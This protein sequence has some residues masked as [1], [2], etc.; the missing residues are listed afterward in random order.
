MKVHYIN[1]LLFELLL[2]ILVNTHRNPC[3]TTCHTQTNRSLCECELYAPSNYDND[4]QM[5]FV[6]ENFNRQT[7]QRFHEYDERMKTTR[8]KCREQCHKEI[9][10]IILKDKMEKQMAQQLTTLETKI[11]TDDIPTCVCE[12]S[13]ADKMEKDCL[14]CTYGLGTLAPTVGLIGSVAVGAWK[15]GALEAAIE[16]AIAKSAAEISAAANAAGIQAGKIAVIEELKTLTIYNVDAKLL[17]SI[18]GS[19]NNTALTMISNIISQRNSELCSLN[20]D[21]SFNG[22]CTQLKISLRIVESNGRTPLLPHANAIR[23]KAQEIVTKVEG[24]AADASA[25]KSAELTAEITKEQT[26]A[27]NTIF[28]SKQTAIIA[29]VVAILIIVLIMVIIYLI[30]RYRRKKKMKKK[31]QYTKLLNE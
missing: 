7:S 5:K 10:K 8:Q 19:K 4:P 17:G 27:I 16:A 25:V 29:S 28:M 20:A 23:L 26:T 11:G 14:R 22:M 21:S 1:I 15:P 13:M 9:E 24:V 12:K 2:K 18:I 3:I 31:A 30:L 6:M